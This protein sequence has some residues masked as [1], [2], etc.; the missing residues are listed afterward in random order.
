MTETTRSQSAWLR[1]AVSDGFW[2]LSG[3]WL[4][5]PIL[6][7]SIN[8]SGEFARVVTGDGRFTIICGEE[9]RDVGTG[10]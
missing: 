2:R 10:S 5:I 4:V 1:S 7:F 8:N 6:V 9:E 3:I